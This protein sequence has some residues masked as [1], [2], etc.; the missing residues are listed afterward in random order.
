[1]IYLQCCHFAL[2]YH[3]QV[4][5][6]EYS[7]ETYLKLT[8]T[9]Q[10]LLRSVRVKYFYLFSFKEILDQD[11]PDLPESGMHICIYYYR[12]VLNVVQILISYVFFLRISA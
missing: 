3:L 12:F 7:C 9:E 5:N 4:L 6:S 10:Y 11:M 1:M 8:I 2:K